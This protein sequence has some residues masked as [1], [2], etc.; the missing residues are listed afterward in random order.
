MLL[1]NLPFL[2]NNISCTTVCTHTSPSFLP[3]VECS[4]V[5]MHHGLFS[6]NCWLLG[7][8]QFGSQVYCPGKRKSQGW[9]EA[10]DYQQNV[11]PR[12]LGV[13]HISS[14]R[15]ENDL[16]KGEEETE[17]WGPNNNVEDGG[18][19]KI[20]KTVFLAQAWGHRHKAL[21]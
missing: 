18:L 3:A 21:C 2:F 11:R 16:E 9:D 14:L 17:H 10:G 4:I 1:R 6:Q 8:C 20:H 15:D 5:R 19:L 13:C 12:K 7:P